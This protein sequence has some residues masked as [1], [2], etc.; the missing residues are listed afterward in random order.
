M[1]EIM[2]AIKASSLI[3]N[4]IAELA[5][6]INNSKSVYCNRYDNTVA[7]TIARKVHH[8]KIQSDYQ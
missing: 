5:S 7:D 1:R 2:D 6:A 3:F 4:I 8:C